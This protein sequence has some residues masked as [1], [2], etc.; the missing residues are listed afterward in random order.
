MERKFEPVTPYDGDKLIRTLNKYLLS[1][2]IPG[3]EYIGAVLRDGALKFGDLVVSWHTDMDGYRKPW[4]EWIEVRR[5]GKLTATI[6][7]GSNSYHNTAA[8]HRAVALVF[9]AA[10]L[11]ITMKR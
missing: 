10:G 2:E 3:L 7:Q 8:R 4:R 1:G 11:P 6:P 5:A 9:R